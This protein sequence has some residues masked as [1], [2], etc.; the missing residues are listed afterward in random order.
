MFNLIKKSKN[1]KQNQYW[2]SP[3]F[4]CIPSRWRLN[5]NRFSWCIIISR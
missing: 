4:Q 3:S 1:S 5:R 2:R